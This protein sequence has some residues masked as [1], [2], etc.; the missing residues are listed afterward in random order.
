ME[1]TVIALSFGAIVAVAL[2]LQQSSQ[3]SKLEQSL[4]DKVNRCNKLSKEIESLKKMAEEKQEKF[5]SEIEQIHK[6]HQEEVAQLARSYA[7][8]K[9]ALQEEIE[10]LKKSLSSKKHPSDSLY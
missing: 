1:V 3:N 5:S 8:D 9:Q 7:L 10:Q 2:L 6:K 4:R